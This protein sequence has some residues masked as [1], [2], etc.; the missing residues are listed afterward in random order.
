MLMLESFQKGPLLPV[1]LVIF[2]H[3]KKVG[4]ILVDTKK[5]DGEMFFFFRF[6]VASLTS[7]SKPT[8]L[9]RFEWEQAN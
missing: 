9:F 5:V 8:A 4:R 7:W 2:E 1:S 3:V 6:V